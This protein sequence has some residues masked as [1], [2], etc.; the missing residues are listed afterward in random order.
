M[1]K[2]NSTSERLSGR[3][4]MD[5][6]VKRQVEHGT[7]YREARRVAREAA[8]RANGDRNAIGRSKAAKVDAHR[9][10]QDRD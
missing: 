10:R 7:P 8:L 9:R 5:R 2:D 6:I 4:A 1:S 3:D